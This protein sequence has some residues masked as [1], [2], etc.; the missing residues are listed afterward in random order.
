MRPGYLFVLSAPS[1]T[2]KS[3]LIDRAIRE[4][5]GIWHSVS[6]T[7]R[8]PRK[9]EEEGVHYYFMERAEFEKTITEVH[10]LEWAEVHG[11]YYGT[12]SEEVDRRLT[13]G[14]DVI[15]DLDVQGALQVK[16]HRPDAVMIFI[17]PPSLE[18]LRKRIEDRQTETE[19][20]LQRRL[21]I[22]EKEMGHRDQYEHVIVNDVLDDA[23]VELAS[24]IQSSR[25]SA[26]EA[27]S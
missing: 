26:D 23:Y 16:K 22:A 9:Y 1:G 6:A 15:M 17:M 10:F 25:G 27:G 18:V 21:S 5:P 4:I 13:G 24:V 20:S 12:P 11:Q 2:G 19:E 3:T 14:E 7:T 8:K